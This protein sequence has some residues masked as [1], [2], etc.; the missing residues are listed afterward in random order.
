MAIARLA[1]VAESDGPGGAGR[2][3]R[4]L[5]MSFQQRG[6]RSR[7][8]LSRRTTDQSNAWSAPRGMARARAKAEYEV[9][10]MAARERGA[11]FSAA[12]LPD[13]KWLRVRAYQPDVVSLHWINAGHIGVET[14]SLMPRPVVW[15]LHD[16]WPLTGGC[17]VNGDC[18]RYQQAC[19]H[20]PALGSSASRDL[21]R[22]TFRRKELAW[23]RLQPT[24]VVAASWMQ[25][26]VERSSLFSDA[27]IVTIPR[28]IDTATFS[29]ESRRAA[30]ARL[31]LPQRA[32][33]LAA[34]AHGFLTDHNKGW[35]LLRS[36]LEALP[37]QDHQVV[38]LLFGVSTDA[39]TRVGPVTVRSRGVIEDP[40]AMSV[41]YN[42]ADLV[43]MPSKQEAFGRVGAEAMSC[44]TPVIAFGSP[45]PGEMVE[46]GMTGFVVRAHDAGALR[47]G[48]ALALDRWDDVEKMREPCRQQA[49]SNYSSE[50][51]A[52]RYEQVFRSAIDA[53]RERR[54]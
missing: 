2:S 50:I 28:P 31:G 10:E 9:V 43:V 33:I 29:P 16:M 47:E 44:G 35:T 11:W 4:E 15:T 42:A 54:R 6:M 48:I 52:A 21:S 37:P 23:R 14:L 53:D 32:K 27:P 22:L 19:G 8:F 39:P 34:G 45:G 26:A 20:C 51:V 12:L 17:H 40:A 7:M 25:Q 36:A 3:A 5:H 24:F 38:L 49:L 1:V 18:T 30:R 41:V 13:L 46:N